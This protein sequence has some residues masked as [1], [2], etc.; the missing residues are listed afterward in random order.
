MEQV[1]EATVVGGGAGGRLSLA[2]LEAS[3]R[4][5]L[6]AVCDL[7]EDVLASLSE[8]YPGIR[9]FLS[10]EEMFREC[11]A[12]VVCVSTFPPS[13]EAVALAALAGP[14]RGILVE[15]P[16][17]DTVAGARR[18]LSAVKARNVPMAVPHGLLVRAHASEVRDRVRRGEIGELKLVEIQCRGWDIINAG[19]H[20]LNFFVALT[21]GDP[22]VEVMA[23]AD[24]STRTFRDGMQVETVA[25]TSAQTR[26]GV[27]VV[28]HTGDTIEVNAP[29]RQFCF[30]LV[31]TAGMI[32]FWGWAPGYRI[33]NAAHPEG[34]DVSPDEGPATAHQIHLEN[35][36]RMI[37]EGRRDYSIPESSLMALELCEAAY[38]SSREGRLLRL[39]LETNEP[40]QATWQPG[41]PY[42]GV[43][44]G[45][46]GR[47]LEVAK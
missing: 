37:D 30:R 33:L 19:I 9:T 43:G 29:G 5:R 13:H 26:S 42:F 32:E 41:E 44:G 20:W 31:G 22:P 23:L 1:Y 4:Y 21:E 7:R 6:K 39:P 16:L 34:L 17:A 28:M 12:D 38:R 14:L 10:H 35:L 3:P 24:S 47:K 45:R 25:V 8:Q 2:A 36:A 40:A 11:P 18:L 46:D 27:R 15:K